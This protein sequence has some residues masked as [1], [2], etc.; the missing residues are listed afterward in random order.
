[1]SWHLNKRSLDLVILYTPKDK[2]SVLS[3]DCLYFRIEKP[4][5]QHSNPHGT[6]TQTD[7]IIL[8]LANHLSVTTLLLIV[9]CEGS[10]LV[11]GRTM[12]SVKTVSIMLLKGLLKWHHAGISVWAGRLHIFNRKPASQT[13]GVESERHGYLT[14]H[15]GSNKRCYRAANGSV[16]YDPALLEPDPHEGLKI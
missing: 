11:I 6:L 4:L 14:R 7:N 3:P 10:S 15:W 16:W 5:K 1:M 12:Q 8:G 13:G 9:H 2:N